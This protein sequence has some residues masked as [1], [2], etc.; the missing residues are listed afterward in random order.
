MA[1]S[2]VG[3]MFSIPPADKTDVDV[4]QQGGPIPSTPT[5]EKKARPLHSTPSNNGS[6]LSTVDAD[7]KRR[8]MEA[9]PNEG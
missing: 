6:I 5:H 1:A 3:G 9:D 8:A 4:T 7:T 2:G